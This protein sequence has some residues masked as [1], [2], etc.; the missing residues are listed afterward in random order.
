[1]T[2]IEITFANQRL[3]LDPRGAVF[4]PAESL[5]IVSD[6]HLEKGSFLALFGSMLPRYDTRDTLLRLAELI[7][8]YQPQQVVCLGDSFHDCKAYDRLPAEEQTLLLELVHSVP[9]WHWVLGNHDAALP[10]TLP[11]QAIAYAQLHNIL[12]CHEPVAEPLPQI[13]GH[14]HPKASIQTAAAK[15]SGPCFVVS[16]NLLIMPAFGSYTGGLSI[17]HEAIAALHSGAEHYLLYRSR[18]WRVPLLVN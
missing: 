1:L 4:W 11:G 18:L 8:D 10:C 12:L 9:R 3:M 15:V 14:F 2:T 16:N 5:L 13:I 6:L 17:H 7:S